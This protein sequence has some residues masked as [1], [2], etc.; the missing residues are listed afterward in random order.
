MQHESLQ[1]FDDVSRMIPGGIHTEIKYRAAVKGAGKQA[2]RAVRNLENFSL[3]FFIGWCKNILV[4]DCANFSPAQWNNLFNGTFWKRVF[5]KT[6]AFPQQI[7][8]IEIRVPVWSNLPA[9][10][11]ESPTSASFFLG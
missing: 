9:S 6:P 10:A 1:T 8:E 5:A 3:T 4:L 2:G 7:K 11:A